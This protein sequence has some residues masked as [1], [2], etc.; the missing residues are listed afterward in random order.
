MI[1]TIITGLLAFF[2]FEV[3]PQINYLPVNS[4]NRDLFVQTEKEQRKELDS[5]YVAETGSG[6]DFINGRDYTQYFLRSEHKPLLYSERERTASLTYCGRVYSNLVLQYD[7]YLDKVI[8]GIKTATSND[9][10]RR[11]AL[12]SDNI[13]RFDLCFDNDTLIF[14]HFSAR[15]D[16][17]FN[18]DDGFYE[19][20][21]DGRCKYLLKYK[22]TR[23]KLNGVDE[24]S[25]DLSG[26]V[27]IGEGFVRITSR[28][29]FVG[30]F[31][32]RS[33]VI[34]QYIKEK[35]IKINK[36]EKHQI[37]DIL[38]FYESIETGTL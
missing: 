33:E 28:K 31:G 20:V 8:Y 16:Q 1:K 7:I 29:Q 19:V 14:R 5:L 4:D 10:V 34:K 6:T 25:F 35:R 23:Y 32:Y 22:S 11:V 3:F 21:Y 30:L 13:S 12:N 36:A 2:S 17:G 9:I 38:K 37:A 15:L 24:Y 26:Y 18:L 27:M